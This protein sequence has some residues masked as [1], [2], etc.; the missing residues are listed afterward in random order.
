MTG[1]LPLEHHRGAPAAVDDVPMDRWA[2]GGIDAHVACT[3]DSATGAGGEPIHEW[4]QVR[5]FPGAAPT[6]TE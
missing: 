4:L 3:Q 5:P 1:Y 6:V 2:P